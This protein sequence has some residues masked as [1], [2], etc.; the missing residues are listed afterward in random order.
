MATR[1]RYGESGENTELCVKCQSLERML[2][3]LRAEID[4]AR[5]DLSDE[6]ERGRLERNILRDRIDVIEGDGAIRESLS[7]DADA[8]RDRLRQILPG[9]EPLGLEDLVFCVEGVIDGLEAREQIANEKV[10]GLSIKLEKTTE[11]AKRL[12]G[13]HERA[14]RF[15]RGMEGTMAD[16]TELRDELEERTTS[17]TAYRAEVERLRLESLEPIR[18]G[19]ITTDD[20]SYIEIVSVGEDGD[21]VDQA[22]HASAVGAVFD[23][24]RAK[25][26]EAE[27]A[28]GEFETRAEG[29]EA[30]VV[31]LR[32]QNA[33][34]CHAL[35]EAHEET[36]FEKKRANGLKAM[37]TEIRSEHR[38]AKGTP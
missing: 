17:L 20:L 26:K 7:V 27:T 38:D 18:L 33:R 13:S 23:R 3:T 24:F 36:A 1:P 31:E 19:T 29:A 37:L 16:R 8:A 2:A 4:K 12:M 10:R 15:E 21:E 5:V 22:V 6:E 30:S 14:A 35:D 11:I 34:L 28:A 32:E 9:D 25:L